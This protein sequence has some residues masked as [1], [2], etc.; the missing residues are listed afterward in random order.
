M[1]SLLSMGAGASEGLDKYLQR[2]MLEEQQAQAVRKQTADEGYRQQDLALRGRALDQSGESNRLAQESLQQNRQ[3]TLEAGQR[4]DMRASLSQLPGG[5]EISPETYQS[6][7]RLKAVPPERFDQQAA[8]SIDSMAAGVPESL[9]PNDPIAS[10]IKLRQTPT[11]VATEARLADAERRANLAEQA[12]QIRETLGQGNL[13]A[14]RTTEARLQSYGGPV[15]PVQRGDTVYNTPRGDAAVQA[16]QTSPALPSPQRQEMTDIT[17]ARQQIAGILE[18]MND[19]QA[20]RGLGPTAG[21]VAGVRNYDPTG[22]TDNMAGGDKGQMLRDKLSK[23]RATALFSSGGKNLTSGE[24]KVVDAFMASTLKNPKV[25]LQQLKDMDE[26]FK[27]RDAAIQGSAGSG[28]GGKKVTKYDL[29][30][31]EVP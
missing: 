4:D 1:A 25:T 18:L 23:L 5:T 7:I 29:D 10:R 16:G 28:A 27:L 24:Q 11:E 14:R 19:E 3:A 22:I 15:I 20:A 17:T 6:A 30:G 8:P 13:D 9:A 2:L 21:I 26:Q 12:L 31:N